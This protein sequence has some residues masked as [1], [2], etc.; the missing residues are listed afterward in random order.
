MAHHSASTTE[1]VTEDFEK[2]T[3]DDRAYRYIRLLSNNLEALL[4]QDPKTDRAG[5]AL[6]V[7]VGYFS[8]SPELPGVAHGVEVCYSK[9]C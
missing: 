2:S 7:N 4:V 6:D 8:D 9:T 5:A 1:C 3:L